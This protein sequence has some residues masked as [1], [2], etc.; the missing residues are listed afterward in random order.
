MV[1]EVTK[2]LGAEGM[3]VFLWLAL[4]VLFWVVLR[5]LTLLSIGRRTRSFV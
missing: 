3:L 4:G 1:S 5:V 2:I